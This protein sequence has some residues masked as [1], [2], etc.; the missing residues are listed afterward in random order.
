MSETEHINFEPVGEAEAGQKLMRLLERRLGLPQNLLHRWLRTGQVR[1]NGRRCKP[2]QTVNAGDEI[3]LPPFAQKLALSPKTPDLPGPELPPLIGEHNG[4][5]AFNK[6][7]GLLSQPGT[8]MESSVSGL[9][10]ACYRDFAFQ[11][12]PAHRLD[13]ETSG[14]LLVGATFPALKGLQA[15]FRSGCIHK[16]YLAWVEG[17]WPENDTVLLR[18]FLEDANGITAHAEP[19]PG[20]VEAIC[21][22]RPLRTCEDKT[23][24]QIRLLTGRKRQIRAQVAAFGHPVCGDRRYGTGDDPLKLHACRIILSDGF[25]FACLPDW[26]GEYAVRDMPETFFMETA[27]KINS[28]RN[29]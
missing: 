3:R 5:W 4:I 10:T 6:P 17:I 2:F 15:E 7:S 21:G 27:G 14:I 23:L 19:A 18:H 26:E 13:R 28:V 11:P 16:E 1:V 22:V 25:Q 12:A 8:G 9:L 24:M 29:I 20:R